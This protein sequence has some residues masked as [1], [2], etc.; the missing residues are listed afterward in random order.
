MFWDWCCSGP[1]EPE[2]VVYYST[3]DENSR[4][5][6]PLAAANRDAEPSSVKKAGQAPSSARGVDRSPATE[7]SSDQ[8]SNTMSPSP[9]DQLNGVLAPVKENE[10][11]NGDDAQEAEKK[12]LQGLVNK[13]VSKA[14][15][16]GCPCMFIEQG[17]ARHQQT[18]YT[19]DEGLAN[20]IVRASL[21]TAHPD[22]F[23]PLAGI[24]DIYC[25]FMD[26]EDCFPADVVRTLKTSD[27][28][29]L[30]VM[31]NYQDG[32][33][34]FSCCWMEENTESRNTFLECMSVLCAYARTAPD[35]SS[36]G[37]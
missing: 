32:Q 14:M 8:T 6:G 28:L 13:F 24:I 21:V 35:T 29:D 31:V 36:R 34:V 4:P 25:C 16:R 20:L 10:L 9:Q 12:R 23:I 18:T 17:S 2:K 15:K 26:G 22:V 11:L 33:D 37:P 3:T 19:L 5:L 1:K 27:E 7:R 30:L